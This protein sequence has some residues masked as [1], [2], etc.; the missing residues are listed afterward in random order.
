MELRDVI[1]SEDFLEEV[2]SLSAGINSESMRLGFKLSAIGYPNRYRLLEIRAKNLKFETSHAKKTS[3]KSLNIYLDRILKFA[4]ITEKKR[5]LIEVLR[6]S[7]EN[8]ENIDFIDLDFGFSLANNEILEHHAGIEV[9]EN[10]L[11]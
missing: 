5:K 11:T 9:N 2:L 6:Y 7:L 4:F 1:F 3:V 10:L 8:I